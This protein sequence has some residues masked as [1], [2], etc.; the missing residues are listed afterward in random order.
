MNDYSNIIN[1]KIEEYLNSDEFNQFLQQEIQNYCKNKIANIDNH[2]L[3]EDLTLLDLCDDETL[4]DDL[5]IH[6][7]QLF[8]LPTDQGHYAV[9]ASDQDAYVENGVA[10]ESKSKPLYIYLCEIDALEYC[11]EN[12]PLSY[13]NENLEF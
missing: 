4:R 13:N 2:Q 12:T 7:S 8:F 6:N 5:C 11:I 10:I 1:R 9:F 3:C